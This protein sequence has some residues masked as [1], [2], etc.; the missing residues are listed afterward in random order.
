VTGHTYVYSF[1]GHTLATLPG[2]QGDGTKLQLTATAEVSFL[3]K[4]QGV[5]KLKDVQVTGPDAQ[6]FCTD[7]LENSTFALNYLL[8]LDNFKF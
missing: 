6:V 3:D 2:Q 1:E 5:L 7:L 4:C 8:K